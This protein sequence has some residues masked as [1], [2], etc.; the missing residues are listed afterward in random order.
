[1]QGMV[2]ELDQDVWLLLTDQ[3]L[4]PP[5]SLRVG[6]IVS[7]RN[8]HFVNPKFYWT[9]VL[10]LGACCKTS[11]IVESFS[12]METGVLLVVSSFKKKFAGILSE[13][14]ILGS[15]HK[16]GLVQTY[17]SSCLR[18]SVFRSRHGVFTEYCKHDSC[19]C[20]SEPNYGHLKL[21]VPISNFVSH[22]EA[23]WIKML[24]DWENDCDLMGNSIQYG[25]PSCEGR[26]CG[27]SIR[28]NLWSEDIGVVLLGNLKIS[29][30]SGRLQLIDATG[31]IDV[32]IPDLLS[33]WNSNSIYEVNDFTLVAEGKPEQ[34]NHFGLLFNES[35]ACRS[36][37]KCVPLSRKINLGIYIHFYLRETKSR[38][39]PFHSR[40]S[41]KGNFEELES[42]RFHLLRV[43][44]KFPSLQK[45]EKDIANKS[46]IFAE[47]IFLP[48]DL[49]LGGKGGDTHS[50]KASADQLKESMEH[51]AN[52]KDQEH[53][54]CKRRKI[55]GAFGLSNAGSGSHG[56]LNFCS[57]AYRKSFA[58]M[59]YSDL[60]SRL[61]IPCLVSSSSG[62]LHCTKSYVKV[63]AG[64][65]PSARKVLLEF[66]SESFCKYQL[67][68][69]GGYYIIKHHEEDILCTLKDFD[70]VSGSKALITS[71][72]HLWSLSFYS[73]EVLQNTNPSC[74]LSF[75][76]LFICNKEV[77]YEGATQI[78][79]PFRFTRDCPEISSDISLYLSADVMSFFKVN[80]KVSE[81]SLV[82][83]SV[84]F[85]ESAHISQCSGTMITASVQCSGISDCLLPEGNLISLHGYVVAVH[86]SDCSSFTTHSSHEIS[87][88]VLQPK[89]FHGVT[90]S[91]CVH[92]LVDHRI[93]K[94]FGA[95]SNHA[96]PV[97][98]GPDVNATFHRVLVLG[99][100][101]ELLLTPA[102]FIVINYVKVVNYHLSDKCCNPSAASGLHGAGFRD[103]VP[104]GLISEIIQCLECKPMQ[105]HCRVV[106]VY[107]LVLE[108]KS[109]SHSRIHS[110]SP[111]VNIPLAGF[112]LDDGSSS[113]CCW[114]NSERAATLLRLHEEIP[115]KYLDR[116][117]WSSNKIETN[118]ACNTAVHQ[119]DKILKKHGRVIVKNHGSMFDSS[120]QDL[121]FSVGSDNVFSSSDEDLL[122]FIILNACSSTFCTVVGSLMDSDAIGRLEKRF[123]E[124]EMIMY[125]VQNIWAREVYYTNPLTE[126]RNIIQ[127]LSDR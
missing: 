48:W 126:A 110:R 18:S 64:D 93:V 65:N 44:H 83:P 63:G 42:G 109:F 17:A 84:T 30:S 67:L 117:Y 111:V 1:M 51:Y 101:N 50:T 34:V 96:Y 116:S 92:V 56:C 55:N 5:H 59:N 52:N 25:L 97:G 120:C 87:N 15:K 124:V 76:D 119:V 99:G 6:A 90:S 104:S 125:P 106:A 46:S 113:C 45:G 70:D 19:G 14:E 36:V 57:S 20:G 24:L 118:R 80:L 9:K 123:R 31:S 21:V 79:L 66:K 105:F 40:M 8:V 122:K 38:N 43:T 68:Q 112:V 58:E 108:K 62:N 89:F 4:A 54:S 69:I 16:E 12:P 103:T 27:Q 127:E 78:E 49:F 102:S 77:L 35:F 91:V 107:I 71:R 28:R 100:Q 2:L 7:L 82:K 61:E 86:N 32:I 95:L 26:L 33:T 47:A 88:D 114:A 98:F 60:S 39:H 22:C 115:H 75:S 72:M 29:P 41:W 3:L 53:V 10:V 81:D 121:T 23:T 74:I 13:K 37:F 94:I 73:D 11:I 85:E